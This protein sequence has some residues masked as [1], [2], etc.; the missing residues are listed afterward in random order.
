MR[1]FKEALRGFGRFAKAIAHLIGNRANGGGTLRRTETSI[2]IESLPFILH[3]TARQVRGDREVQDRGAAFTNRRAPFALCALHL[4]RFGEQLCVEIEPNRSN[5]PRLFTAEQIPRTTNL[6]VGERQLES[7]TKVRRIE[8][9]LQPLAC[10]VAERL[11]LSIEEIA[12]GA[13]TA[14]PHAPTELIELRQTEFV[15]TVHD[16]RV[17]V[18]NVEARLNDGGADE[19]VH[20][21]TDKLAHHTLQ[22][23]T[24]HLSVSNG[25]PSVR[26]ESPQL[27]RRSLNGLNAIV[28]VV[29]LAATLQLTGERIAHQLKARLGHA[30][31]H[32]VTI[33]W[34]CLNR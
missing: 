4:N 10:H 19:D 20:F 22:G 6:K 16:D 8:D 31:R 13:P 7:S 15:R 25:D 21:A 29:R 24:L 28:D 11:L 34:R 18:R 12:P 3:V 14:S 26:E 9:C 32:G 23:A 30:R 2:E 5:V 17:G 33:L 1:H 27:F